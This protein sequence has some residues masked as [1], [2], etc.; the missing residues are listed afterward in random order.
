MIDLHCHSTFS[1]GTFSPKDLMDLAEEKELSAIAITD[2]DEISANPIAQNYAQNK[3]VKFV[4]GV[5]LSIDKEMNGSAHLHLLGLFIDNKNDHLQSTL[6]ELREARQERA[7]K[8]IDKL[9]AQGIKV[10]KNELEKIIGPGSAGR[11]HIAQLLVDKKIVGTVWEAFNHFLS[12][13]KPGYYPKKKLRLKQAIDLIHEA[14][15]LAIL[16]HPVSL[17]YTR[18]KYFESDF[19]DMKSL[20]LDGIE[21]YYSTHTHDFFKFLIKTAEKLGLL[22]SGGSDFHGTTKPDIEL[23]KGKGKLHVPDKIYDNLLNAL[24]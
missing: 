6:N 5:E 11:P 17:R 22:I 24:N 21:A 9:K 3:P 7:F 23:G 20:G 13:G 15:G 19:R 14:N 10:T 2:H 4:P 8:I 16:A 18:Y 12:K 1:D